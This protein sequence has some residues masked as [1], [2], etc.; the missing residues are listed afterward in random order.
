[1]IV[2]ILGLGSP[3]HPASPKGWEYWCSTYVW[4][5]FF[6]L[7]FLSFG[8]LFGHQYSHCWIDFKGILDPYMRS[9]GIDYFENSRRATYTQQ[10]Y[11]RY[12]PDR[13][14]DYGDSDLGASR[15]AMGPPI[16]FSRWI[17]KSAGSSPTAHAGRP[18]TGPR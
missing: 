11:A 13:F 16:R 6:G 8:P 18:W 17:G 12:N 14:R 4:G 5:R 7:E 1:M 15:R 3:T 9:K 10:T 2:Y